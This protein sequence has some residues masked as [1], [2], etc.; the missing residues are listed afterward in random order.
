MITVSTNVFVEEALAKTSKNAQQSGQ[1]R[2]AAQMLAD[3]SQYVPLDKSPL[4]TTGR[5]IN[6][7]MQIEWNTPY[8]R[9][10]FYG[11]NGRAVF[12]NYTT[13]G[14]GKRWDLKATTQHADSWKRVYV[15]GC[16]L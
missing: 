6:N 14:T 16:G 1:N 9:A 7:S 2:V 13:P 11:A 10:Q 5:I 4:R 12:R 3:M 8:A 15:K